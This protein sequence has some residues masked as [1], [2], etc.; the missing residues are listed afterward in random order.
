MGFL[1]REYEYKTTRI[2]RREKR[3]LIDRVFSGANITFKSVICILLIILISFAYINSTSDNFNILN[4]LKEKYN[5]DFFVVSSDT[6]SRR[7]ITYKI[8]DEN[9][10]E[11]NAYKTKDTHPVER[12]DDY[13]EQLIKRFA[14]EYIT[15]NDI[16][17]IILN[18][19]VSINLLE[20]TFDIKLEKY[21][22]IKDATNI[23]CELKKHITEEIFNYIEEEIDIKMN[24]GN[25]YLNGY[26]LKIPDNIKNA[27]DIENAIKTEYICCIRIE[28]FIDEEVTIEEINKYLRPNKL[29]VIIDENNSSSN[30]KEVYATYFERTEEYFIKF[31]DAVEIVDGVRIIEKNP[32]GSTIK[33]IY[34]NVE[35]TI[36]NTFS[37]F[38]QNDIYNEAS[39]NYFK[40]FFNAKSLKY[41]YE[42]GYI[43]INLE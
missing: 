25:V 31:S 33:F 34:N 22:E 2:K 41:D 7:R 20:L 1:N 39:I 28:N 24:F 4:L 3:L 23:L 16:E 14:L 32:D 26:E 30:T 5:R 15:N 6:N 27:V 40:T 29:R 10:F 19:K 9:G 8:S 36:K 11:F 35:Y 21:S 18:E 42:G 17:N 43:Y 37:N 38:S 12:K 13:K